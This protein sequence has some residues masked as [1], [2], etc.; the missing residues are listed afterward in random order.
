MRSL[1]LSLSIAALLS[2]AAVAQD[3]VKEKPAA[4]TS[5][6]K[7]KDLVLKVP[8]TWKTAKGSSMRLATYAIPKVE[9]DA[10]DAELSIF[11][12]GGGG[13]EVGANITR[14]LGQ[15]DGA[16]RTSKVTKGMAGENEYYFVDISGT[17]KKPKP[18][19]PPFRQETVAAEGYRMLGVILVIKDKGV[20]YLKLAG[21]KKTIKAAE[22]EYRASFGGDSKSEKEYEL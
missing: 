5:E 9:G 8:N 11:N 19:S 1:L 20:Y 3:A 10:D 13:G 17:F 4:K 22:A 16:G 12:F 18:G 2:S 21:P 7:L 15:F 6:V 14:W